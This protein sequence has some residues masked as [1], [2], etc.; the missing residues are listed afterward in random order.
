MNER[1]LDNIINESIARTLNEKRIRKFVR[2]ATRPYL[3]EDIRNIIAESEE[4][5][6][7]QI[8]RDANRKFHVLDPNGR[9]L[10]GDSFETCSRFKGGFLVRRGKGYNLL[11]KDGTFALPQDTDDMAN[12]I[13]FRERDPA[14][15]PKSEKTVR[16]GRTNSNGFRIAGGTDGY[17][18]MDRRGRI[19]SDRR[20][21]NA[22]M[23]DDGSIYVVGDDN[24]PRLFN[25]NTGTSSQNGQIGF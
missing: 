18:I 16:Y 21:K 2:E 23:A 19:V 17:L 3:M 14:N 6:G 25:P 15:Q 7:Y 10:V 1:H 13:T 24:I 8:V 20:Y 22:Y 11:R 5:D 12:F 4:D 9:P